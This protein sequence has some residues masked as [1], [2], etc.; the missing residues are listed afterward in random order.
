MADAGKKTLTT[1]PSNPA[2]RLA[3]LFKGNPRSSGRWEPKTGRMYTEYAAL[4]NADFEAHVTGKYGVGAVPILDDDTCTWAAIDIDN[5][6]TDED[7]PIK[8]ID[9]VIVSQKLP[10]V[11]CRSKSGGVH[12]YL[13]LT[14]PQPATTVRIFMGKWAAQLGYPKAEVFP[15]Q[16]KLSL[17]KDGKRQLGNWLNLPYAEAAKTQRYAVYGGKMLSLEQ[18]IARAENVRLGEEGFRTTSAAEHPEAPP[19]IQKIYAHGIQQGMRNEALYNITVYHRKRNPDGYALDANEANTTVFER[20]LPKQEATRT[21]NSAGRPDYGYRCNEEPIRSLCDRTTCLKR[22]FGITPADIERIDT[23]E[24]LPLFTGLVKYMSEPIRWEFKIDGVRVT[25]VSTFQLLD[26]KMIKEMIAE[27]LTKVVPS[28]KNVE[29]E[30]ILQPLMKDARI[31]ST[32]DEASVAG[33]IRDRLR[34][35]AARTDLLSLGQNNDDRKA[36]L[37]GMPVVISYEGERQVMFRAQDFVNFLKRTKSEELKGVNLWFAVRD[38]GVNHT[39]LR[40]GDYNINLWY[41]PVNVVLEHQAPV[42]APKFKSEL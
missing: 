36:L 33:V 30:R 20:A 17:D 23:V 31:V 37:R 39:K 40:V 21:I 22:K 27:R 41:L 25:N 5:H 10:L 2:H 34:E 7:V 29:W 28:L 11:P 3:T 6:D 4:T 35:F 32:P 15:K 9:E 1:V 12:V 19:C 24:A 38:V 8:A 16:G 14:K 42:E 18:F 26:F 13:F